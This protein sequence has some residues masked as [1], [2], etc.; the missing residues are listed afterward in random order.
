M[1]PPSAN[2]VPGNPESALTF[3]SAVRGSIIVRD[4]RV[5]HICW[6]PT[7]RFKYLLLVIGLALIVGTAIGV[8]HF[9]GRSD[10]PGQK[11]EPSQSGAVLK[12]PGN[13]LADQRSG[14][15]GEIT[16]EQ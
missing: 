3:P 1:W 11:D 8:R 15:H 5:C 9:F 4:P 10:Q 16:K 6:S 12:E 14:T 2:C 13:T 7:M